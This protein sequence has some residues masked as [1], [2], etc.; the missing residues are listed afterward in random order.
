ME[1]KNSER[2]NIINENLRLIENKDSLTFGTDAY[3]LSAYLPKRAKATGVEL[4]V[5]SGVISLIALTK[6]KCHHVYGF[7]VQNEIYT[8]AKR[9]AEL[10]GLSDKFTVINKDLRDATVCDTGGEVDFVFSNPPYMK[11]TSGK[12]NENENKNASRHEIFGEIN[13]F[14]ACAKKLLR[15]GGNFYAVYRPDRLIDLIYALRSNNLEPKKIT[16]IHANSY[17]PPSLFLISAK[18][19]GKS[20][21]IVD[22]PIYI[23]KDGTTEYTEQFNRIYENCS[24]EE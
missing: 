23:Y 24:F 13:D 12:L 3:L 4:G 11:A 5:G 7:E 14:C 16:F 9:N 17:T 10:N 15:H 22:K 20:G 8:I 1:I 6:E 2:I 21:L 19:G 18:L